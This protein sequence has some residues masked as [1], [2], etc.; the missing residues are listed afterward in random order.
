MKLVHPSPTHR[1][2]HA[3]NPSPTGTTT[4]SH[5]ISLLHHLQAQCHTRI[6]THA[7]NPSPTHTTTHSLNH[8]RHHIHHLHIT[9][10][11]HHPSH[12]SHPQPTHTKIH[13]ITSAIYFG[14]PFRQS[15]D[16]SSPRQSCVTSFSGLNVRMILTSIFLPGWQAEIMQSAAAT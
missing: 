7:I 10:H 6:I 11:W 8:T 3:S 4:H 16:H 14:N 13:A 1:T 2:T 15:I 9:T 12:P 5:M